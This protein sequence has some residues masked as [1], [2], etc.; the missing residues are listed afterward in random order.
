MVARLQVNHYSSRRQPCRSSCRLTLNLSR[1]ALSPASCKSLPKITTIPPR[2]SFSKDCPTRWQYFSGKDSE[3]KSS[4]RLRSSKKNTVEAYLSSHSTT[5]SF[6]M[7][8][9]VTRS[10]F[11]SLTGSSKSSRLSC[12]T[13]MKGTSSQQLLIAA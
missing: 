8:A 2:S 6:C 4:M 5:T 10:A 1:R 12:T 3:T 13:L 9:S 7:R 11:K